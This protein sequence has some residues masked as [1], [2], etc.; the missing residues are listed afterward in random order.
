MLTKSGSKFAIFALPKKNSKGED[1]LRATVDMQQLFEYADE[2]KQAGHDL[3]CAYVT[4]YVKDGETRT[5]I[6]FD[7]S[8]KRQAKS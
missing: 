4:T 5:A 7:V 6:N 3:A 8:Y 1:V 2:A